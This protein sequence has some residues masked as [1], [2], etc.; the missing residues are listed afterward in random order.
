M[1]TAHNCHR[2][3]LVLIRVLQSGRGLYE[4]S[5]CDHIYVLD[6]GEF[7]VQSGWRMPIPRV[8]PA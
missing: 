3:P 5:D 4:C 1:M 8:R 2:F 7:S 6:S